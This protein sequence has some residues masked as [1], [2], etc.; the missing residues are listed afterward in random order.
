VKHSPDSS[1]L[2]SNTTAQDE[3]SSTADNSLTSDADDGQNRDAAE[4]S[5]F[6]LQNLE[7]LQH[8][9]VSQLVCLCGEQVPVTLGAYG[10]TVYCPS[11]GTQLYTAERLSRQPA[12]A[13]EA[14][15]SPEAPGVHSNRKAPS[16]TRFFPAIIAL[17]VTVAG[18]IFLSQ[19]ESLRQP[20][21]PTLPPPLV[22]RV[23]ESIRSGNFD[24]N[25]ITHEAIEQL[26]AYP[27]PFQAIN[28]SQNWIGALQSEG[29]SETDSRFVR[30]KDIPGLV[31]ETRRHELVTA[32]QSLLHGDDDASSR[33]ERGQSFRSAV[34]S[35]E[36]A[37]DSDLLAQLNLAIGRLTLEVDPITHADI[38][39]LTAVAP[40][41]AA[42]AR[43]RAWQK[44]F[45][46]ADL[47]ADEPR[48]PMLAEAIEQIVSQLV[49]APVEPVDEAAPLEDL[50]SA[51]LDSVRAGDY[52]AA[53]AALASA[54]QMIDAQSANADAYRERLF[55]I[56]NYL[57][58]M[59]RSREDL[60]PIYELIARGIGA[61]ENGDLMAAIEF[62]AQAKFLALAASTS[63]QESQNL[64]AAA[65]QLGDK[66]R[67]ARGRRAV[68]DASRCHAANDAEARNREV[69]RAFALLP[70]FPEADVRPLLERLR[71]WESEALRES[72]A[73]DRS[74]PQSVPAR[75][76]AARDGYETALEH[77]ASG[78]I[79]ALADS[80]SES[81]G[82]TG[83]TTVETRPKRLADTALVALQMELNLRIKQSLHLEDSADALPAI[84]EQARSRLEQLQSWSQHPRWREIDVEIERRKLAGK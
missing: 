70:G 78:D 46:D 20:E 63:R 2:A 56:E 23:D 49:P 67:L 26:V 28:Y 60:A 32:V 29:A 10:G 69:R 73:T 51:C 21:G 6:S 24:A 72:S 38:E 44:V 54:R 59:Q 84:L 75:E 16:V 76:I 3:L 47:P 82:P 25:D 12:D 17:V 83:D 80:A 50:I 33:L 39:Q 13:L 65:R 36:I 79:A 57:N 61:V 34:L 41:P 27:D 74:L 35:T 37:N 71:E 7:S 81:A 15:P 40:E 19:R 18:A 55:R 9:V 52:S 66:I 5:V 42:L 4:G 68:E 8:R 62:E 30:L 14:P 43:A 31:L 22:H 58:L 11:C 77:L 1:G 45:D 53:R 64:R 48:V